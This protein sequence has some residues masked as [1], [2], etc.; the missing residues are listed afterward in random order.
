MKN[1]HKTKKQKINPGAIIS[2][3]G[4]SKIAKK[5]S[6]RNF[7]PVIDYK[8]CIKCGRCWMFCPDIAFKIRKDGHFE[9][10]ESYCKGCGLCSKVC[11]VKCI[12][13]EVVKQ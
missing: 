1:T 11:P 8:K 3:P 6:Y 4:N 10:I 12:T 7:K 5:V 9:N 2:K 13:M